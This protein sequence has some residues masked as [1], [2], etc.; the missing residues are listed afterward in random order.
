MA[1]VPEQVRAKLA[2]TLSLLTLSV[3]LIFTT[4]EPWNILGWVLLV[5]SAAIEIALK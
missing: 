3:V 5:L 1:A 4:P 2:P